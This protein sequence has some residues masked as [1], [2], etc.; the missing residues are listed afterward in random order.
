MLQQTS[1]VKQRPDARHH[2]MCPRP[3]NCARESCILWLRV[4]RRHDFH[5]GGPV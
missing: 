2:A 1:R 5:A 3:T 4:A